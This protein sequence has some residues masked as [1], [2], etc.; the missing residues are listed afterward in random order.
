LAAISTA[1]TILVGVMLLLP[2][3]ASAAHHTYWFHVKA[4]FSGY[5]DKWGYSNPASHPI[6]GLSGNWATDYYQVSGTTGKWYAS[7]SDGGALSARVD[8]RT[9]ACDAGTWDWAGLRY[10][11]GLYRGGFSSSTKHGAFIDTHV[12]P[13]VSGGGYWL[14]PGASLSNGMNI[15]STYLYP[16]RGP[17]C[18][19]VDYDNSVHWHIV[20]GNSL[21]PTPHYA[22]YY[23]WSAGSFLSQGN[24][25]LG[26]INA[27]ATANGQAC[28]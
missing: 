20:A 28:Y 14:S 17:A 13:L 10:E 22:C 21:P 18:W 27:N 8:S 26:A 25:V 12:A 16:N 19:D 1:L 23:P 11:I 24:G 7:A 2:A 9:Y 5:W 6:G 3:T 4:P 15:G